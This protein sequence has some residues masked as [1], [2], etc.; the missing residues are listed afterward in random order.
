MRIRRT[1]PPPAGMKDSQPSRCNAKSPM[2]TRLP[3]DFKEFLKLL[4]QH[5]V[6]YLL[7]GGYAV[8]YY[9]YPRPTADMDIWI[10]MRPDNASRITKAL[11]DFGFNT[12][13]LSEQLFLES[14]NII[15][16]GHPPM[17]LEIL[18]QISGLEFD[19]AFKRRTVD[20]IDGQT[21]NL[22]SLKDL[23]I[24]KR[25]AGRPKD[26]DDLSKLAAKP[27]R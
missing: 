26:L 27:K 6:D 4:A 12:P 7:I 18:T 25:A 24:N 23:K 21:I 9:G 20:Q 3:R 5:G 22:I 16:M 8:A 11:R 19:P 1:G 15:R 10:A 13:D 14:G 2:A 17:R